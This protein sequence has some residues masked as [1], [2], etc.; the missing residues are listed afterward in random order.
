MPSG[1]SRQSRSSKRQEVPAT[2]VDSGTANAEVHPGDWAIIKVRGEIDLPPLK[3]DTKY[4]YEFAE[5]IFRLGNDYS[6]ASSS[7]PDMSVSGW[8]T[9]S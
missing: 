6:R 2:V 1:G 4:A 8:I 5:P 9:V 3:I 7:A